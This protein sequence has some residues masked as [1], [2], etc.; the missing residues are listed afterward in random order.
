MESEFKKSDEMSFAR[1]RDVVPKNEFEWEG[2][3]VM[4]DA[5]A[6]EFYNIAFGTGDNLTQDD[7]DDGFDDYIM[8]DRYELDDTRVPSWVIVRAIDEGIIDENTEGVNLIDGGQLLLKRS[9]WTDGDIRRF[10]LLAMEFAGYVVEDA[11][12]A[13]KHVVYIA[14]EK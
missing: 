6:D 7:V 13:C 4:Y 1:F 2:S 5:D 3:V 10:I 8:V 9:E 14:S 11:K 12:D